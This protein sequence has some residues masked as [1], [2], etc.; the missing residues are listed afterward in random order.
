MRGD[1]RYRLLGKYPRPKH[2]TRLIKTLSAAINPPLPPRSPRISN[3]R[4]HHLHKYFLPDRFGKTHFATSDTDT[5]PS[6]QRPCHWQQLANQP[7]NTSMGGISTPVERG[8]DIIR[9]SITPSISSMTSPRQ[10]FLCP[11]PHL[12]PW[13]RRTQ[14]IEFRRDRLVNTPTGR[15]RLLDLRLA[16]VEPDGGGRWAE[17]EYGTSVSTS[18]STSRITQEAIRYSTTEVEASAAAVTA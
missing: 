2:T 15:C 9:T 18:S 11:A 16:A 3:N 17:D 14:V 13:G 5:P 8:G 6:H 4:L 1:S 12:D 7:S 10:L